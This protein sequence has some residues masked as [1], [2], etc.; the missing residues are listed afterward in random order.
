MRSFFRSLMNGQGQPPGNEDADQS[1]HERERPFPTPDS[2]SSSNDRPVV[3]DYELILRIGHGAYGDVWL[4]R[5][6]ATGALRAA[7]I[8]WRHTF[9]DAK[10]FQR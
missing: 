8:V 3:P 10:P 2:E 7:K 9:E 5:S 6:K 4:A 1:A